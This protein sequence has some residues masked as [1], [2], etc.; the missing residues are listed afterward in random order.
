MHVC[1]KNETNLSNIIQIQIHK[2]PV[3]YIYIQ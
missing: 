3:I 1:I 2:Q